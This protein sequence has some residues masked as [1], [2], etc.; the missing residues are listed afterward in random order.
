MKLNERDKQIASGGGLI[1]FDHQGGLIKVRMFAKLLF[2][3]FHDVRVSPRKLPAL[4]R[5]VKEVN[6]ADFRG[7]ENRFG[8]FAADDDA[9]MRK[10]PRRLDRVP[11]L[12]TN[13]RVRLSK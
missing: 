8:V 2:A 4:E 13:C 10:K 11:K 5:V 7:N 12:F 1:P 9:L 6:P 3:Q